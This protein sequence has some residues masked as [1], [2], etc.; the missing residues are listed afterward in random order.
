MAEVDPEIGESNSRSLDGMDFRMQ[1]EFLPKYGGNP[2]HHNIQTAPHQPENACIFVLD[3]PELKPRGY[4]RDSGS[5][6]L[7]HQKSVGLIMTQHKGPRADQFSLRK[8]LVRLLAQRC[9]DNSENQVR[10][11]CCIGA[12]EEKTEMEGVFR[13][14]LNEA[15][16]G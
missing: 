5:R 7:E 12:F 1:G 2:I 11:E 6:A 15:K 4:P 16:F 9:G 8:T 3:D 14:H 13:I 10:Q